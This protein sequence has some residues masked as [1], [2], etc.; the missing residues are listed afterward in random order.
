MSRLETE[1]WLTASKVCLQ[2]RV[3]PVNPGI[4][5][6]K[7][8]PLPAGVSAETMLRRMGWDE[9]V[10]AHSIE[11]AVRGTRQRGYRKPALDRRY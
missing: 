5:M 2:F 6:P 10:L 4:K 9:E 11:T 1:T 8:P 7:L 3:A